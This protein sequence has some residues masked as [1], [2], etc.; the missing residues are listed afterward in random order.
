MAQTIYF[1]EA[2][3]TGNHL[4]DPNQRFFAYASVVTDDDEAK[5]FVDSLI[6]RYNIQ[7]GEL[8][9]GSLVRHHKGRKAIDEILGEFDGRLLFTISDKKYAL[10]CKLFEYIF[11]PCFSDINTMFYGCDFHK[12]I[13]TI[14]YVEFMARGA[15][16]EQIFEEFQALMRE[17]SDRKLNSLF[18]ASIHPDNSPIIS[19]VRDLAQHRRADIEAELESLSGS[20]TGKWVLDVTRSSLHGLLS[21]WGTKYKVITAIC[22]SSKPLQESG[23]FFDA[24][25]GNEKQLFG[26][27][28]D[29][30]HPMTFNLSSPIVFR[31]SKSTHGIQLADALAGAAVH[32]WSG[33]TDDHA[34]KWAEM[35]PPMA[36][37]PILPD[38]D[39]IDLRRRDV[40][41]NV[42]LLDQLHN[43]AI[44][45]KSLIEGMPEVIVM[46]SRRLGLPLRQYQIE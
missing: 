35:L 40:R 13:S 29:A 9:G 28:G 26:G 39:E 7:N 11:E 42:F 36:N 16:A 6:R 23:E 21:Q 30:K 45:G 12:F 10:A 32:V 8:K 15:G 24:M 19:Q 43:R 4:L 3:Y 25:V 27:F 22:D 18:A 1:D 20:P 17:P 2:G 5:D 14:L 41:R 44:N 34:K 31:D 33:G 46:I 37:L 38:T